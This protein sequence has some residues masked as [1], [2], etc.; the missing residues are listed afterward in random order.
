MDEESIVWPTDLLQYENSPNLDQQWTNMS[1]PHFMVWM[2][3]AGLPNFRKLYGIINQE[4]VPG[5]YTVTVNI[6]IK[7]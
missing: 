7:I 1:D 5:T 6:S 3:V 2:K 4:L